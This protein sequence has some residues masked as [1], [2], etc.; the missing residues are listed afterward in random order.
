MGKGKKNAIVFA[1]WHACFPAVSDKS[2]PWEGVKTAS[3]KKDGG[4]SFEGA[5]RAG[6]LLTRL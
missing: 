5:S 4:S 3:A 2:G 6:R 1:H